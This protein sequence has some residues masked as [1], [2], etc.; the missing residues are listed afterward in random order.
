MRCRQPRVGRGVCCCTVWVWVV[1]FC[2]TGLI[3][4]VKDPATVERVKRVH[5]F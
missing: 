1:A 4:M 3:K 2:L 5:H